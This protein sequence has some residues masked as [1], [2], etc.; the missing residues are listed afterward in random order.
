LARPLFERVKRRLRP[1]PVMRVEAIVRGGADS[2]NLVTWLAGLIGTLLA[3]ME[4]FG[5]ASV[6]DVGLETLAH[7]MTDEIV[8]NAS[9]VMRHLEV[10]AWSRV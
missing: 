6:S 2:R 4:R 1:P 8:A 7:R 10:G 5:I 9:V 3:S